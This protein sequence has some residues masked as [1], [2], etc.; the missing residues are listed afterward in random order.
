MATVPSRRKVARS[1]G[2]AVNGAVLA[3]LLVLAGG[4]VAV[5]A[6]APSG[7]PDLV[8]D[9]VEDPPTVRPASDHATARPGRVVPMI[10][11]TDDIA[12]PDLICLDADEI[13]DAVLDGH[14]DPDALDDP[15]AYREC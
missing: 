14:L 3:G 5:F 7:P 4:I 6:T 15:D 8:R 2:L 1:L 10:V 13:E 12:E 9:T 11:S